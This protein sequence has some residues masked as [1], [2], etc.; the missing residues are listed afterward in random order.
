MYDV[1]ATR[2]VEITKRLEQ[3]NQDR[4][5]V[6]DLRKSKSR[7]ASWENLRHGEVGSHGHSALSCVL[8][9][10]TSTCF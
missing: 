3:K 9:T 1:V 10:A 8:A 7:V 5:K 2:V 6:Q 4:E